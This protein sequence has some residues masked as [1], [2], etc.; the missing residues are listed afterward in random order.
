MVNNIETVMNSYQK[1]LLPKI[2]CDFLGKLNS[3][4]IMGGFVR[5][6]APEEY[7]ELLAEAYEDASVAVP[8]AMTAF[9]DILVWEK[10]KYINSVNIVEHSVTVLESSA[11]FFPEDIMDVAFLEEYLGYDRYPEAIDKLGALSEGE[12]FGYVPLLSM[13]GKKDI[14][15]LQKVKIKEYLYLNI[16]AQ[17]KTV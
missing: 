8:F 12:I 7:T 10:G 2:L 15:M 4:E 14:S 13:G 1:N 16:Q 11:Q 17:S 6:F 3:L 9:G 5:F